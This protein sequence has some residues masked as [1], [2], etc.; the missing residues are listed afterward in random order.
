MKRKFKAR[1]DRWD[2]YNNLSTHAIPKIARETNTTYQIV[3][4]TL[5]GYTKDNYDVIKVAELY[6]A[7]HIWKTRFCRYKS[8]LD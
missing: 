8:E 6:A 7:I 5:H 2:I 1:R 4:R 3:W